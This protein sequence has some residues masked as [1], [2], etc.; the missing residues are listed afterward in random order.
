MAL[1]SER[2]NTQILISK[3]LQFLKGSYFERS[4]MNNEQVWNLNGQNVSISC[5]VI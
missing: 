5:I 1:N 3:N 2:G 4:G